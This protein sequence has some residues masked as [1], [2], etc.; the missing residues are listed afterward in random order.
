MNQAAQEYAQG[1]NFSSKPPV[2]AKKDYGNFHVYGTKAALDFAKAETRG[3]FHTIQ[4]DGAVS[5]GEKKYDWPK[6]TTIQITRQE[7]QMVALV[8]LGLTE[9]CAYSNHGPN[10]DK[11]FELACQP[12]PRG[13]KHYFLRLYE[14]GKPAIAVQINAEDAFVIRNNILIQI[15]KN[16]PEMTSDSILSMLKVYAITKK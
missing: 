3:G 13:G 1:N 2:E 4:I 9:K 6:K 16:F 14:K 15:Q 5:V 12:S 8:F 10:N 11:G 7:I